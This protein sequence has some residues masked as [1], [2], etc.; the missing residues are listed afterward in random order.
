MRTSCIRVALAPLVNNTLRQGRP[1]R[2]RSR[3]RRDRSPGKPTAYGVSSTRVVRR[4]TAI[5]LNRED[6]KPETEN[7]YLVCR[8]SR[9]NSAYAFRNQ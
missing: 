3:K 5:F 4:E 2:A 9:A 6:R 8:L 7:C 1:K